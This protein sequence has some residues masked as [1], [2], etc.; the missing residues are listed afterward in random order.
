MFAAVTPE[1][2]A[3]SG[4]AEAPAVWGHRFGLG[5]A[6]GLFPALAGVWSA[7]DGTTPGGRETPFFT[8]VTPAAADETPAITADTQTVAKETPF[9]AKVTPFITPGTR[10]AANVTPSGATESPSKAMETP[11]A[12]F[13]ALGHRVLPSSALLPCPKTPSSGTDLTPT[14]THWSGEARTSSGT[15]LSPHQLP[16]LQNACPKQRVLL[17]F[18][19][20]SDH[21]LEEVTG[22][23]LNGLYGNPA[24]PPAASTP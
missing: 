18:S 14:A 7:T 15:A 1:R 13:S 9:A 21:D 12:L 24:F 3:N 16:T 23:V 20:A 4:G 10:L 8:A 17:G 5:R 19:D 11:A 6:D 22:A 2:G